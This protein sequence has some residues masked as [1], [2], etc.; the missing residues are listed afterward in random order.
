MPVGNSNV[1]SVTITF[2]FNV[3]TGRLYIYVHKLKA[4]IGT[5]IIS[6]FWIFMLSLLDR[7]SGGN[8][9]YLLQSQSYRNRAALILH[10]LASYF[11]L[12]S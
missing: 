4:I 7:S 2:N 1:M 6:G 11:L 8:H 10:R 5:I 9:N 12:G 3:K